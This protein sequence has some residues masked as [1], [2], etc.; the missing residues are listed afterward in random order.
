MKKS[1]FAARLK[2]YP[3]QIG[4][5]FFVG[6]V[7]L[8]VGFMVVR[9][10]AGGFFAAT[11]PESGTVNAPAKVVDDASA[12]A[13]KALQFTEAPTTPPPT[14]PTNPPSTKPSAANTGIPAGTQLTDYTG[15]RENRDSNKTF[16]NVRFPGGGYIFWGSNLT[17]RNCKF[18]SGVIFEGSNI[19]LDHCDIAGD[20]SL[21]NTN[22]ANI[23]YNNIHHW[24]DALHITSEKPTTVVKNIT[25]S[26]NYA[27]TP[28]LS[29]GA[30][31]D[32]VQLLG[33]DG[34]TA[35]YNNIDMGKQFNLCGDPN[36][37]NAT[38]QIKTDFTGVVN[39]NMRIENNWLNGGGYTVR[40]YQCASSTFSNN[41]FGR[42]DTW[43]PIVYE[44]G[45]CLT[46]RSG[47]VYDDNN[48]PITF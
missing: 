41:R 4:A 33:I 11:E 7:V 9:S 8:V 18:E 6:L 29:C 38:F 22:T 30:H 45:S 32:G 2:K 34:F 46:N 13:G 42:D 3:F 21:N 37:L 14:P 39:K 20:V 24:G 10:G 27:H 5:A 19:T 44:A 31:S 40:L 43:G 1:S 36:P 15:A 48:A 26:N 35:T 16:A 17:L 47:N 28:Q 12:S 25:F 23:T